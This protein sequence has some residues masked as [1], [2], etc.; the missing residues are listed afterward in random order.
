M[1]QY[2]VVPGSIYLGSDALCQTTQTGQ[3]HQPYPLVQPPEGAAEQPPRAERVNTALL[4]IRLQ[5]KEL[6]FRAAQGKESQPVPLAQATHLFEEGAQSPAGVQTM[7]NGYV[8]CLDHVIS[9]NGEP[10]Y[11]PA[12]GAAG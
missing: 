11:S 10:G 9:A 2:H 8:E 1:Y 4:H 7:V 5:V 3:V 12:D 6:A